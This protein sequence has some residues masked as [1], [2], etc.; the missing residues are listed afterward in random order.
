[1]QNHMPR[2]GEHGPAAGGLYQAVHDHVLLIAYSLCRPNAASSDIWLY[3]TA[4]LK[5]TFQMQRTKFNRLTN[6]VQQNHI[7]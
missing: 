7:S 5:M 1:M 4:C 3:D 6:M 2:F